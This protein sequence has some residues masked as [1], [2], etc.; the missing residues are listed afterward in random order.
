MVSKSKRRI[1]VQKK[2]VDRKHRYQLLKTS[3]TDNMPMTKQQK[4]LFTRPNELELVGPAISGALLSLRS[5]IRES[6]TRESS[7]ET[8]KGSSMSSNI[9]PSAAKTSRKWLASVNVWEPSEWKECVPMTR[10]WFLSLH[11]LSQVVHIESKK[12]RTETSRESEARQFKK[13]RANRTY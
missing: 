3:C 4:N 2:A 9:S 1:I 6:V 12:N 8:E 13:N 5:F 7:D 10:R 11:T